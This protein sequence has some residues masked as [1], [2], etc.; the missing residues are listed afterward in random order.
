MRVYNIQ[1]KIVIQIQFFTFWN[2]EIVFSTIL[3][4]PATRCDVLIL[5]F[6]GIRQFIN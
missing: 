4:D 6:R 1:C 2:I 3:A 5:S